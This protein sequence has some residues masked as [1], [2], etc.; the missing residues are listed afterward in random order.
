[1]RE[2]AKSGGPL[3]S[4]YHYFPDGKEQLIDE[5]IQL[6][7]R[8]VERLLEHPRQDGTLAAYD[9]FVDHWRTLLLDSE[10]QSGCAVLAVATD[11][12]G[13]APRAAASASRIFRRW[14]GLLADQLVGDGAG[15][16]RADRVAWLVVSG[17][18]GA[19]ALARGCRSVEP[20]DQTAAELRELLASV[21]PSAHGDRAHV[22]G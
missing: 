16:Q 9:A 21:T 14:Q 13:Q 18:E 12:T 11:G 8:H 6:V 15:P 10:F 22:T 4:I 19:L 17:L 2:L 1:M 5:A 3:G 20:L 7:G